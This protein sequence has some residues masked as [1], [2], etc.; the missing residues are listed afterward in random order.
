MASYAYQRTTVLQADQ[1]L[2]NTGDL[3]EA[4]TIEVTT[5]AG[6]SMDMDEGPVTRMAQPITAAHA[7]EGDYIYPGQPVDSAYRMYFTGEDGG[8]WAQ[9]TTNTNR[10]AIASG[11][12]IHEEPVPWLTP[13]YTDSASR[14]QGMHFKLKYPGTYTAKISILRSLVVDRLSAFVPTTPLH[15][16]LLLL[17]PSNDPATWNGATVFTPPDLDPVPIFLPNRFNYTVL[18]HVLMMPDKVGMQIDLESTFHSN[19]AGSSLA[20]T[21]TNPGLFLGDQKTV[22]DYMTVVAHG[23]FDEI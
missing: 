2:V 10:L 3:I 14:E 16:Y 18:D 22:G 19:E 1:V 15:A 6:V 7:A 13:F 9:A 17:S 8:L 20:V 4:G 5:A 12:G 11:S 21:W 23:F